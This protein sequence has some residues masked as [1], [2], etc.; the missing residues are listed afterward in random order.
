MKKKRQIKAKQIKAKEKP[1]RAKFIKGFVIGF[2]VGLLV[3]G[4]VGFCLFGMLLV[5]ILGII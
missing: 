2:V 1:S 5:A 3:S 4:F